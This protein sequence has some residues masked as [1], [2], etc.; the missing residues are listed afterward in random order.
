[1]FQSTPTQ[2]STEKTKSQNFNYNSTTLHLM[3]D[4]LE[5]MKN[6]EKF[7][8]KKR[9][10]AASTL[11]TNSLSEKQKNSP[12]LNPASEEKT[13]NK[14]SSGFATQPKEPSQNVSITKNNIPE[15]KESSSPFL[16]TTQKGSPV[17]SEKNQFPSP[18]VETEVKVENVILGKIVFIFALFFLILVVGVSSYY[19]WIV[20]KNDTVITEIPESP[21]IETPE[22]IA[23]NI[24]E[25]SPIIEP[26]NDLSASSANRIPIN[27][28]TADKLT[29]QSKLDEY[30]KKAEDL[31]A[32]LPI[33]FILTDET[34]VPISFQVFFEKIGITLPKQ[35][36]SNLED[37]F[38]LFVN[39]DNINFRWG[40]SIG[41]KN[42]IALKTALLKEE[43]KL[44][45][46]L[47]PIL[48]N[49][50]NKAFISKKYSD[51]Q[52]RNT[53]TRYLNIVSPEYLSIDYAVSGKKLLIGTT[54][55]TLQALLDRQTALVSAPDTVTPSQQ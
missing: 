15:R 39:N 48:K 10:A 49:P 54:R 7:L 18:A 50:E 19:F 14:P 3:K 32:T 28:A 30:F 52:Y 44:A 25:P 41:S 42:D 31:R 43:S 5:E 21:Q 12:F 27:I 26:K 4:D 45:F 35:V 9:E 1:M 34:N 6:P 55:N 11:V 20:K 37:P 8:L 38:S 2:T 36:T 40:F 53:A 51:G 46:D 17:F 16:A 22:Q 47:L 23:E 33:E 24:P 29:L 13:V